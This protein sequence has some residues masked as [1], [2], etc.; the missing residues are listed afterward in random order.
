MKCFVIDAHRPVMPI[1][2]QESAVS[3]PSGIGAGVGFLRLQVGTHPKKSVRDVTLNLFLERTSKP[4]WLRLENMSKHNQRVV[5]LD[6]DPIAENRG[7][8]MLSSLQPSRG[9]VALSV[10]FG[11]RN[12][13]SV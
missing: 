1:G 8:S 5:V 11:F 12:D 2:L 10:P 6:D 7:E 3:N 9:K 4:S 13:Q